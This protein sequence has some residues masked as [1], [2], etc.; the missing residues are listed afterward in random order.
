VTDVTEYDEFGLYQENADEWGLPW[1]GPPAVRRTNIE[2]APG[3]DVSAIL[4]GE[5]PAELVLLHGGGQNAHTWDTLLLALG[6]P[7]IAIDLPG[8]GHS[9]WRDDRDYMPWSNA[10]AVALVLDALDI[11][12]RAVV[13]MSLGGLTTIRLGSIRPD[14]VPKAVIVDV[15]PSV[16]SRAIEMTMQERGSTALIGG[17]KIYESFDEMVEATV[18]LTP[19]RPRSALRR[20]VLHNAM[21]LEDGRWRWRYDIGGRPGDA[22]DQ[23]QA[24]RVLD[25]L[26][27]W[28]DVERLSMPVLL[29]RGDDS[30]FVLDEHEDEFHKRKPD[31]D[32]AVVPKA[33]HAVQSDQ[34]LVLRGL[35]EEFVFG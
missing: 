24:G 35:V 30:I 6:R 33:G 11:R 23:S 28:D 27:L 25:F 1:D 10:D 14:L 29:V 18:A 17:P 16:H 34:P 21:P 2:V 9:S 19:N 3:Q 31:L 22:A 26:D 7:A 13:G 5:A 12:P 15:T 8:H 20:G 32:V 4:W